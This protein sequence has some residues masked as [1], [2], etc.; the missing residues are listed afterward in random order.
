MAIEY[1][2]CVRVL[3]VVL[4]AGFS[5]PGLRSSPTDGGAGQ[6]VAA[7][8]LADPSFPATVRRALKS[9]EDLIAQPEHCSADRAQLGMIGRAVG[10]QVRIY[11]DETSFALFT[12]SEVCDEVPN[13]VVRMGLSGRDRLREVGEFAA[14]VHATAPHPS[15]GD[16]DAEALG[17]LVERLDDDGKHRGLII[18][19]PHGGRIEPH[20]D[21]QAERVKKALA[22]KPVSSWMCK[23]WSNVEGITPSER[24]HI[25]STDIHEAS[26][27]LL[28]RVV[29][30]RFAHAVSFHGFQR[31]D[32]LADVVI[33]GA[34]WPY[35]KEEL[36]KEIAG[37]LDPELRVVIAGEKDPLNGNDPRNIVNR[38]AEGSGIQIEQSPRA[39]RASW[40]S[41]ADAVARVYRS[42]L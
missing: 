8:G 36:R 23:G 34:G 41:I 20:T 2:K 26:F 18:I 39:R 28:A 37:S 30:R 7:K 6:V 3:P 35:L 11:R 16:A 4:L 9:Q 12:V 24:W 40:R 17:E 13:S 22:G 38:L 5:S 14:S 27:P 31:E 25:T 32:I 29:G 21:E 19:A 33:G 42:K 1:R 15:L 10:Q